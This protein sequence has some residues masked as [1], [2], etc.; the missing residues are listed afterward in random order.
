[1]ARVVV[2]DADTGAVLREADL[3]EETVAYLEGVLATP[4]E[5][6]HILEM[7]R[8]SGARNLDIDVFPP[9]DLS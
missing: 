4:E 9:E 3:D 2:S 7:L 5:A 6:A 8:L 1:M